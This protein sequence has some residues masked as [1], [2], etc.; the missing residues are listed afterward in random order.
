[1][2][3]HKSPSSLSLQYLWQVYLQI[4]SSLH[5]DPNLY[6]IS[7]SASFLPFYALYGNRCVSV[8]VFNDSGC[9]QFVCKL[10]F[11]WYILTWCVY[12][13]ASDLCFCWSSWA[14]DSNALVQSFHHGIN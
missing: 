9:L 5:M 4:R 8:L 1:M 7:K 13:M 2:L 3:I 6:R 11:L 14:N 12:L 10:S